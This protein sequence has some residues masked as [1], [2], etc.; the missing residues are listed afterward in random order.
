MINDYKD[1]Y[2][3]YE[4]LVT[5]ADRAF[6]V[7]QGGKHGECVKCEIQCADCCNSV[8]GLFPIEALYLNHHFNLLDEQIKQ[9]IMLKGEQTDQELL[10]IQNKLQDME[11]QQKAAALARERVSCPLLNSEQ[12]CSLYPHRPITCRVYGIPT[13]ISGQ[14]HSCGKAGFEKG[15]S[16][17]AFNLDVVYRELYR[18]SGALLEAGGVSEPTE[19]AGLLLSVP[20]AIKTPAEELIKDIN[21]D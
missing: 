11:P 4:A 2:E 21:S 8:F 12:K 18:L 3:A 14:V 19:Q 15:L 5:R 17:P 7:L 13:V 1:L 10:A 16:Y 9:E 20:K 6:E